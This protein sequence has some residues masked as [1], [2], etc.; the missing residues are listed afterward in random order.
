MKPKHSNHENMTWP[1]PSSL[2]NCVAIRQTMMLKEENGN[3]WKA[4]VAT[5]YVLK[6][7]IEDIDDLPLEF[8]IQPSPNNST[9]GVESNGVGFKF[10]EIVVSISAPDYIAVFS[11]H[12]TL[13]FLGTTLEERTALPISPSLHITKLRQEYPTNLKCGGMHGTAL[14]I[15]W[16]RFTHLRY[17]RYQMIESYEYRIEYHDMRFGKNLNCLNQK[18]VLLCVHHHWKA[19]RHPRV[20]IGQERG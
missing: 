11:Q 8:I 9:S 18:V 19:C 20:T 10:M 13:W 6:T 16:A 1:H 17:G 15:S 2:C 4:K 7:N 12:Y 5:R 14:M 3:G